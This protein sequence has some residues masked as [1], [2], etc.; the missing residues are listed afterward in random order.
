MEEKERASRLKELSKKI[1]NYFKNVETPEVYVHIESK[2]N[3]DNEPTFKA[4]EKFEEKSEKNY[5]GTRESAPI[6]EKKKPT[7][8]TFKIKLPKNEVMEIL[9]KDRK[10]PLWEKEIVYWNTNDWDSLFKL[11]DEK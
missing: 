1:A 7:P 2:M 5:H 10:H 9:R 4:Q 8:K 6:K 11:R 3:I